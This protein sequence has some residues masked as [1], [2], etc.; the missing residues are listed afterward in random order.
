MDHKEVI[1]KIVREIPPEKRERVL[2]DLVFELLASGED[3]RKKF[4]S[5]KMFD[6]EK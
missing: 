1:E 2:T 4:F 5:E 6:L 3:K